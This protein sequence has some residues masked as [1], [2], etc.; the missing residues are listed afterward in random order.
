MMYSIWKATLKSKLLI[1]FV[2]AS[3]VDTSRFVPA[4]SNSSTID[5]S[6]YN[7]SKLDSSQNSS[8]HMYLRTP[9]HLY[10]HTKS[11]PIKEQHTKVYTIINY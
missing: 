9:K 6:W 11:S 8:E 5:Q 3:T 10:L 4:C 2:V 1:L 7:I